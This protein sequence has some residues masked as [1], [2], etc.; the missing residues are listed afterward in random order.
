MW[1]EFSR[2]RICS[3]QVCR[4]VYHCLETD[5][6]AAIHSDAFFHTDGESAT[7]ALGTVPQHAKC[8]EMSSSVDD[9]FFNISGLVEDRNNELC[10][11]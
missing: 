11:W 7:Q 3:A 6:M 4:Q 10:G 8:K 9:I 1:K 5:S 2:D